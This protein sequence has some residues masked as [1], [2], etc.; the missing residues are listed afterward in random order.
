MILV[1]E[2]IGYIILIAGFFYAL[3]SIYLL[4]S[5]DRFST[6]VGKVTWFIIYHLILSYNLIKIG[7]CILGYWEWA[8]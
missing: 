1:P 2:Y 3:D 7:L 5:I 6:S 4:F 8:E